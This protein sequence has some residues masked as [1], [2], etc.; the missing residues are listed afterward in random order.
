M[1]VVK[2][3]GLA[4]L[5]FAGTAIAADVPFTGAFSG[6]GRACSGGLYLRAKTVEWIS[7]YSICKRSR[8]ELLAKDLTVDHQRIAVRI[9][10]RS[11]QCRYEIFEAEQVSTYSWDVRGYKTLEAYQK[12]DLPD[13]QNSPLPERWFLSCPMVRLN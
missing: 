9:K 7:T 10:T 4:L 1:Q 5:V 11:K 2:A 3:I 13:W 8:Y 6:T 12:Q